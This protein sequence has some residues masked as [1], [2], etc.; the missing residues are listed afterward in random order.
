[1]FSWTHTL[2]AVLVEFMLFGV[3]DVSANQEVVV[4][5]D[6]ELLVG[7]KGNNSKW[8]DGERMTEERIRMKIK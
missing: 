5:V 1:M 8:G 3:S 7:H 6:F 2:G 4:M